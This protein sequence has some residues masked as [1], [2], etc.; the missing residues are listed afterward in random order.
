[1]KWKQLPIEIVID[2]DNP[3]GLTETFIVESVTAATS[4]WDEHTDA[5]LFGSYSINYDASWDEDA[6][7]GSNELVFGDYPQEG[8]I[9]VTVVWGYFSGPP[10]QRE[11][12]EFD[13]LFDTD[14]KWGDAETSETE[15]GDISVMDLQNIATHELGHG[16]GLDDL[17]DSSASEETMYGYAQNGETKKRT[18]YNGDIAGIQELY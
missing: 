9:A 7:D 3:D 5:T 1:V 12:V 6:P 2:P 13:I 10:G 11:I 18:L 15:L 17:Y 8:V 14:Y 4:E 16:L